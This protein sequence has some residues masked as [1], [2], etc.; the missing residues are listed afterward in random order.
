MLTAEGT[1]RLAA[2]SAAAADVE[3]RLLARLSADER[4]T[5]ARLLVRIHQQHVSICPNPDEPGDDTE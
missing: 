2:A 4:A 5:L 3:N 1:A